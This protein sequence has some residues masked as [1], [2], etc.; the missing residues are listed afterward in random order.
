VSEYATAVAGIHPLFV[1]IV[2]LIFGGPVAAVAIMVWLALRGQR[3]PQQP[4]PNWALRSPDGYWWWDGREWQ[5]VAPTD[6]GR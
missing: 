5:P 6:G 3:P 2:W 1:V 4:P